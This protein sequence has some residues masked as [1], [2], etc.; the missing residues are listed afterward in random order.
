VEQTNVYNSLNFSYASGG[1]FGPFG[2][3]GA[4]NSTGT[5]V[6]VDTYIFP[7]D[8]NWQQ[9]ASSSLNRYSQT[10]YVPSGGTWNTM[11]Y[12]QGP[13]CWQFYVGN[14]AFDSA[15]A[16]RLSSFTD[17]TS[18]TILVGESTRFLNDPDTAF[19]EWSRCLTLASSYASP[20]GLTLRP[21]GL[22]Y[23]VPRINA[24]LYPDDGDFGGV[25]LLAGTI[26]PNAS[27]YKAWVLNLPKYKEFGQWGFRSR[28][29]GGAHFVFGDGSVRFLKQSIKLPVY[30]ALGTRNLGEVIGTGAY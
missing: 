17:G 28:H 11:A 16:Y 19:N 22:A 25:G 29:P 7:D 6:V 4:V 26:Y 30:Q 14:G 12:F 20:M 24:P 5:A 3:V 8:T 21:Q 9:V 23:E 18:L 2:N 10:S 1:S 15:T 27:D 13:G